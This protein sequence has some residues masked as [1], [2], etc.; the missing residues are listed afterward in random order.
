MHADSVTMGVVFGCAAVLF[1][2]LIALAMFGYFFIRKNKKSS[3]ES[4]GM[5][6]QHGVDG[7]AREGVKAT[8]K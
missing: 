3:K 6:S 8:D 7:G 1:V 5:P 4:S 2:V